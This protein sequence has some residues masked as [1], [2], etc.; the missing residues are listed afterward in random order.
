MWWGLMNPSVV[1]TN[2]G[3]VEVPELTESEINLAALTVE[4]VRLKNI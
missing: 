3:V 2:D 4:I 1:T